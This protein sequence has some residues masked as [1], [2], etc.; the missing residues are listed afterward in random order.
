MCS[1]RVGFGF[2]GTVASIPSLNLADSK[3]DH[4]TLTKVP[5]KLAL[6][7]SLDTRMVAP[8]SIGGTLP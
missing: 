6:A 5:T 3:N 4:S 7:F 8:Q 1:L 2:F